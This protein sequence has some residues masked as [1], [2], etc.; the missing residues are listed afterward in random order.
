MNKP[1]SIDAHTFVICYAASPLIVDIRNGSLTYVSHNFQREKRVLSRI[2]RVLKPG[3]L[4]RLRLARE[5]HHVVL[6]YSS[7]D[8]QLH[9]MDSADFHAAVYDTVRRIPP[10]KVTTYGESRSRPSANTFTDFK[11]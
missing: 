5:A 4:L 8:C 11:T 3:G 2:R 7:G 9:Y 1:Y 10:G 6:L